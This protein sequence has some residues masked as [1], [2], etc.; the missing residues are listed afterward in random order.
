MTVSGQISSSDTAVAT[1]SYNLPEVLSISPSSVDI[2]NY[3]AFIMQ[4]AC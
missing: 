2:G 4:V 1:Y 3:A